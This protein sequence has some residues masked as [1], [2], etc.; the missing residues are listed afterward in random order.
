GSRNHSPKI[1]VRFC[2]DDRVFSPINIRHQA[3]PPA[4]VAAEPL[5]Q[6]VTTASLEP[7]QIGAIN[8]FAAEQDYSRLGE[9]EVAM[10]AEQRSNYPGRENLA[11]AA[12]EN[13]HD[14]NAMLLYAASLFPAPWERA[15]EIDLNPW[16]HQSQAISELY[17]LHS[18]NLALK[19]KASYKYQYLNNRSLGLA[20]QLI[21]LNPNAPTAY[22][23][24]ARLHSRQENYDQEKIVLQQALKHP[25]LLKFPQAYYHALHVYG[26]NTD[27]FL[28]GMR[29]LYENHEFV[30]ALNYLI[31]ARRRSRLTFDVEQELAEFKKLLSYDPWETSLHFK[32]ARRF[33][34]ANL[35]QQAAE[36]LDLAEKINPEHPR[37]WRIRA[38]IALYDQDFEKATTHLETELEI[39]YSDED[40]QRLLELVS[41]S[42]DSDSFDA[43]YR[44]ALDAI[45]ARYPQTDTSAGYPLETL[46]RRAVIKVNPDST[47]KR[48]YRDVVRIQNS[49]GIRRMARRG[50]EVRW[51]LQDLRV[52]SA[53]VLHA[54]GQLT[55]V[56]VGRGYQARVVEFPNLQVGDI[57][58]VEYRIDDLHTSF[59]GTYFSLNHM[60][61]TMPS[62]PTRKSELTVIGNSQLPLYFNQRNITDTGTAETPG[63]ES[64]HNWQMNDI[65]PLRPEVAM[66]HA[67]ELMPTVQASSYASWDEFGNWWWN[68]IKDNITVSAE[69]AAK[70]KE[71]TANLDTRQQMLT[72]IYEFVTN[73]IRYNAW[74]FGVHGYQPYTAPVIFSRRFGDCKDKAILLRAMLSEVDIEALPVLIMRS[75][76]QQLGGRRPTQD[77]SLAMVEHFNH[78]IA[79][80][81]EQDG[82][83]AQY[84]DGTANL[85]PIETLPYDDRGADVV[86]VGPSGSNRDFIPFKEADFNRSDFTI[87]IELIPDGSAVI[88]FDCQVYGSYDNELRHTFANGPEKNQEML[89][90]IAA[91]LFGTLDGELQMKFPAHDDL[92]ITPT[93]GFKGKFQKFAT[94]SDGVLEIAASP[95]KD[96]LFNTF[97]RLAE[98][99]SDL[100]MRHA[101]S[102]QRQYTYSLPTGYRAEALDDVAIS[103]STGS[104]S[105]SM[106]TNGSELIINESLIVNQPRVSAN[107]YLKFRE[108]CRSV[109]DTQNLVIE[110]S[111]AN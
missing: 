78:C 60:M 30:G 36:M 14:L 20:Q 79:Y 6:D 45:A 4:Q 34:G 38:R 74:E 15:E 82:I 24:L 95:L 75:A 47:A 86:V 57:V 94:L 97:T 76:T 111:E 89:K 63:E 31:D 46:L 93:Y 7:E 33:L 52:L 61:T 12:Q 98:R 99:D 54:D 67:S 55:E 85:T 23:S 21:D 102:H 92:S 65:M 39:D 19:Y 9:F 110:I 84:L 29:W 91:T 18:G 48:Y 2:A 3:L 77:L 53:S 16:L 66:P 41:A 51:G 64:V 17:P 43:P 56:P 28:D 49:D 5:S 107:D 10:N 87:G 88:D 106:R 83:A 100:V 90:G 58:D 35:P 101:F 62:M 103:N 109:N 37:L 44:E 70:V 50:F 69:M 104:F 11:R 105:W 8:Y 26:P 1:A 68:L 27:A 72:A 32:Y 40:E 96:D 108:L 71:L 25:L 81:P 73:E 59:F 80:I 13:P 42:A 22:S